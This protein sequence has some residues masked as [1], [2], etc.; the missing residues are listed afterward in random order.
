MAVQ[1]VGRTTLCR[2]C[3]L[4]RNRNGALMSSRWRCPILISTEL[5]T[6]SF[7][8]QCGKSKHR[9]QANNGNSD[10]RFPFS[11]VAREF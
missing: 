4:S 10:L 2:S 1:D 8:R 11:G 6:R 9:Q 5:E 7:A 3:I